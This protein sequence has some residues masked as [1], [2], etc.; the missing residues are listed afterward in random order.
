LVTTPSFASSQ[1]CKVPEL[2]GGRDD[3]PN[4]PTATEKA[5]LLPEI[6]ARLC[7]WVKIVGAVWAKALATKNKGMTLPAHQCQNRQ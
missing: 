4:P 3:D 7:G 6:T 5:A 2:T 1:S